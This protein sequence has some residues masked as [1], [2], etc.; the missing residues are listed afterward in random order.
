M[1][2]IFTYT[3]IPFSALLILCFVFTISSAFRPYI[4]AESNN[5]TP[6]HL[7]SLSMIDCPEDIV[8]ELGSF[9][10]SASGELP[11]PTN[12]QGL[13]GGNDFIAETLDGG[14]LNVMGTLDNGDLSVYAINFAPGTH[15][16]QYMV[17]DSCE[18]IFDCEFE[19]FVPSA[20]TSVHLIQN[21]VATLTSS[22]TNEGGIVIISPSDIDAGSNNPCIPIKLELRKDIDLCGIPGNATY[23][24]DGHLYDGN[25]DP[26]STDYDSDNGQSIK[27]CCEDASSTLYD[28]NG[29]GISEIGYIKVWMRAWE[30]TNLDSIFGNEG[31][32]YYESS[33]FVKVDD[34]LPPSILCPQDVTLSCDMDYTDLS[35]T[36]S[37]I[38]VGLCGEVDVEYTDILIDLSS[39][40]IGYITRRWNIVGSNETF[41]HQTITMEDIEESI[42]VSFSQVGDFSTTTCP[43]TVA[44]GKPTWIAGPCDNIGYSVDADSIYFQQNTCLKVINHYTVVSWC[45]YKPDEPNWNG[46][47]LW[48]HTQVIK[49]MDETK[50][51]IQD[52]EDKIYAIND[53]GDSDDD[54]IV[55]EAK[56]TLTN[57]AFD[58]GNENCSTDWLKWRV[59]VDL[60]GDGTTDLEYSSYLPASDTELNDTNGNGIPDVHLSPTI[61]GEMVNIHL[62][63][64]EGGQSHH[65]VSWSVR[66][67]CNNVSNCSTEFLV[68]DETPPSVTCQ[69]TIIVGLNPWGPSVL[70]AENYIPDAIDN[71]SSSENLNYTFSTNPKYTL[72]YPHISQGFVQLSIN[73]WDERGNYSTCETIFIIDPSI[74]LNTE[75]TK[76]IHKDILHQNYPNPFRLNTSVSFTLHRS[77]PVKLTF[78]NSAGGEVLDIEIEGKSGLN[79]YLLDRDLL[80]GHGLYYYTMTS[81]DHKET[82]KMILVN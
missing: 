58:S 23:N 9:S 67:G 15:L 25:P 55:C 14:T 38:A 52:C 76:E 16:I 75:E 78:I 26:K 6:N 82:R 43:D 12:I 8:L 4:T 80:S 71:C 20:N 64:I 63:D 70:W 27:F 73:S 65:K 21:Y 60:W 17:T 54:G 7:M 30:D 3:T 46:E 72:T 50:P 40:Y 79:T 42:S 68:V 69:D 33:T 61:S 35:L 11:L 56:L 13:C 81:N 10:C 22:S 2:K 62:P 18:N 39:C 31:D 37:A 5:S 1:K 47:G 59:T 57:V 34:K 32:N 51:E 19:V 77:S 53:H 36:G 29:D 48:E 44:I 24:A 74:V 28:I 49:I 66:D 45:D 41:C